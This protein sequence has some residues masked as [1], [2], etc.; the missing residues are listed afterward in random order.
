MAEA[1]N[2]NQ[3]TAKEVLTDY[4]RILKEVRAN[5]VNPQMIAKVEKIVQPLDEAVHVDFGRAEDAQR[6]PFPRPGKGPQDP[7]W[8]R[9]PSSNSSC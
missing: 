2:G 7:N 5:R 4:N 3:I 8:P 6:E 9:P 1:V